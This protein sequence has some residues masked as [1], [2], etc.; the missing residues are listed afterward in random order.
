MKK[1][2]FT[3]IGAALIYSQVAAQSIFKIDKSEITHGVHLQ[4]NGVNKSQNI[5]ENF[6]NGKTLANSNAQNTKHRRDQNTLT[7]TEHRVVAF[8]AMNYDGAQ[9]KKSYDSTHFFFSGTRSFKQVFGM[10]IPE[11]LF[12][13]IGSE[14]SIPKY[15]EYYSVQDNISDSTLTF[16]LNAAETDFDDLYERTI[17]TFDANGNVTESIG[18]NKIGGVWE[19]DY[20]Y[21]YTFI[22]N[23]ITEQVYQNWDAGTWENSSKEV[24]AYDTNGD[25]VEFSELSWSSGAWK[26]DYNYIY[27]YDANG[28]C[29][30]Q[31]ER[32]SS[33]SSW[34]NYT[35]YDITYDANGNMTGLLYSKW[36][37]GAWVQNQNAIITN[38]SNGDVL[39]VLLKNKVGSNWEDA[40]RYT[41][42]YSGNHKTNY[43]AEEFDGTVWNKTQN[44]IYAYSSTSKLESVI[45]QGWDDPASAWQNVQKINLEYNSLNLIS[46]M[47]GEEWNSG[48]YWEKTTGSYKYRFFYESYQTTGIHNSNLNNANLSVYPNPTSKTLKV[49]I[50][51][52]QP[53]NCNLSIV[54]ISGRTFVTQKMMNAKN[55]Q[56]QFDISDLPAGSYFL[57][58]AT[59][60]G[61]VSK[62]FQVVK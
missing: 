53:T 6:N 34:E 8:Y 20:K 61:Q 42:T 11:F 49:N 37:G 55:V 45:M 62:G 41:Y 52:E 30:V 54:D 5:L 50:N 18:R 17:N 57:K 25:L 60:D 9:Y 15:P 33:G 47:Y 56:T 44:N 36:T 29:I 59:S 14:I 51:L 32:N 26:N 13:N 58:V 19:N 10:D 16:A 39:S 24:S 46:D 35:K 12:R 3:F 1:V 2:F 27:Q 48:G 38:N 7:S 4:N 28:N 43:L 31:I 40:Y 23:K 22:N 21:V